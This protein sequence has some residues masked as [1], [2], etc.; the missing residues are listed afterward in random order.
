MSR[1]QDG[2]FAY[3]KESFSANEWEGWD[4]DD[5]GDLTIAFRIEDPDGHEW[6]LSVLVDQEDVRVAVY[7]TLIEKVAP[8]RRGAIME[9]LTRANYALPVGNFEIDLDDGE[10]CFKTY[11]ELEDVETSPAMWH[12]LF[13]SN[14]T[15]MG[16]YFPSIE[17]VMRGKL[18][19]AEAIAAVESADEDDDDEDE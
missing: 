10:V 2:I 8:K 14:V 9:L 12:H 7:S 1:I 3:L 6:D 18:E 16:V 15:V 19:V 11:L 4:E 13:M 17:A 5:D